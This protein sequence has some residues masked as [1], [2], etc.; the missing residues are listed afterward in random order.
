MSKIVVVDDD[1][2][3][4]QL[5][6][7][8][9]RKEAYEVTSFA[10]GANLVEYVRLDEPECLILD[11][12]MPGIDGLSLLTEI[13]SFT[14]IPI[15]MI[16]ARGEESDRIYGLELG[17]SDF[18]SKP[19]NPRELVGRVKAMLRLYK[20]GNGS[21]VD[22][23]A[24]S[25]MENICHAGNLEIYADFRR[26]SVNN[27]EIS[28]TSREFEL[29]L[30]LASHLERPFDREQLI[31][32]V[33]NYDFFGD[34]RVVDDLVKRIRKKLTEHGSSLLINT[35]WGFGYKATVNKI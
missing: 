17:C 5:L 7:E 31:Q 30:F 14:E 25:K 34:V 1:L 28:L 22:P 27:T 6:S 4:L 15:I 3:I 24:A 9:L 20:L 32:H 29:L 21:S 18:L 2:F 13:R 19:F 26:V 12:M 11:I 8:Y 33:W 35:V 10:S 23:A 16:S